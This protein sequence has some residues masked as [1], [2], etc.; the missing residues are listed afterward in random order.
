MKLFSAIAEHFVFINKFI[1]FPQQVGS[2]A[3]S[4]SFLARKMFPP[5]PGGPALKIAELGAGTGAI[6]KYI[7]KTM[8]E[9]SELFLFE[10]DD[11]LRESLQLKYE[12]Q[13]SYY[14][15][16]RN[17]IDAVRDGRKFDYILSGLPFANFPQSLRN[18]I[19][20][21]AYETL[22]PGGLFIAFQY[23]LQMKKLLESHFVIERIDFVPLNIPPAFVYVCRKGEGGAG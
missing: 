11:S 17:M 5:K 14:A 19:I 6:T 3:P 12:A 15:E 2:I 7:L 20:D 1:R 10:K 21:Q 18:E 22:K 9:S 16:A 4:S 13:A 8:P 23:S